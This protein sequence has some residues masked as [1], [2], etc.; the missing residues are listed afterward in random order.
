[1]GKVLP[2][3]KDIYSDLSVYNSLHIPE[4]NPKEAVC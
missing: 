1:M 3:Q 4:H 2:P